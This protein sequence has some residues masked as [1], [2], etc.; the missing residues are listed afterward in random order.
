MESV[1]VIGCGS[2]GG[3]LAQSLAELDEVCKLTIVDYDKVEEK[4]LR[5]SIFETRDVG[6]LKTTALSRIINQHN[7]DVEIEIIEERFI[8]GKT[9]DP[10]CDLVIDCRDFI[11]DRKGVIDARMYMSSRY[12]IVDCR[13]D[14]EYATHHKGRYLHNLTKMDLK[15]A[16]FN[17]AMFMHK[18]LLD[19]VIKQ[20]LVHKIELDHL[21]KEVADSINLIKR[22][23]DEVFEYHQ[24]E[25]NLI[26]LTQNLHQIRST[27]QEYDLFVYLGSRDFPIVT[28]KVP[29]GFLKSSNDVITCLLSVLKIPYSFNT[30]IVSFGKSDGQYYVELIAETGAA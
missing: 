23:P 21:N 3:F 14:V 1:A 17:A 4:N 11:Y 15:I 13:K 9:Q 29:R 5:N 24:G 2:L 27:N 10:Q 20:Q 8:E 6:Q 26:N 28:H 16:A 19:N 30:Y 25:K 12:L 22:K 7:R 18:G